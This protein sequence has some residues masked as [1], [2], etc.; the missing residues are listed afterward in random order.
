VTVL[1]AVLAENIFSR[2]RS[3]VASTSVSQSSYSKDKAPPLTGA[4]SMSFMP[5]VTSNRLQ[6]A[7]GV[8]V[9]LVKGS[10]VQQK[11]SL[12]HNCCSYFSCR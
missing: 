2:N 1:C 10:L 7:G 6:L 11:V 9:T 5:L 12:L 8:C 3:K 4:S